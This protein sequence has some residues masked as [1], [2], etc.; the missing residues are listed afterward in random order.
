MKKILIGLIVLFLAQPVFGLEWTKEDGP[1]SSTMPCVSMSTVYLESIHVK[2]D[3]SNAV[4]LQVWDARWVT[5]LY[6]RDLAPAGGTA[7]S[8]CT[9]I[10][11]GTE[12][13]PTYVITTGAADRVQVIPMHGVRLTKGA[14]IDVVSAGDF[15]YS[16]F[17]LYESD[18]K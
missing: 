10:P 8:K 17:Y 16:L 1:Y 5:G 6:S 2:T 13:G 9:A 14:F 4:T 11:D 3:G 7:T 12:V 18:K 15:E